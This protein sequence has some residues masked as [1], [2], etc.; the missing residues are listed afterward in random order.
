MSE[1]QRGAA[2]A[3][4]KRTPAGKPSRDDERLRQRIRERAYSLWEQEG[5]PDGYAENHWLEAERDI[6]ALDGKGPDE[7]AVDEAL[8]ESFPA[9]D[10]PAWSAGQAKP[11]RPRKR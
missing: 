7:G 8:E 6:L 4:R 11:G 10:P 3:P 5:R 2:K 1:L 9:S